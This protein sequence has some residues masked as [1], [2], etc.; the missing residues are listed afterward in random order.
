MVLVLLDGF[1]VVTRVCRSPAKGSVAKGTFVETRGSGFL[2]RF[3]I[4]LTGVYNERS[5]ITIRTLRH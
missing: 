5:E 4:L 1:M 3:R 2:A